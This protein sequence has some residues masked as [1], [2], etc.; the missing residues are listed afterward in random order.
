MG[1]YFKDHYDVIV[2]GGSLAGLSSALTL[3]K[4][5]LDVLVL[6]QH[7]LPG[8]VATSFVRGGVEME[9]SLHEMS[10]I[11]SKEH[12]LKARKY[13]ESFGINVDWIEIPY[14]Y[15][16]VSNKINVVVRPGQGG[17]FSKPAEDIAKACNDTDGSIYNELIRFFK[18]CLYCH[19]VSDEVSGTHVSKVKMVMK[20]LDYVKILGYSFDEVI[21]SFKLPELAI[22]I[23]SAYWMYLGSPVTDLPFIIYSYIIAD[24]LGYGAYIPKN[25]S[26]E[27]ALRMAE[28]AEEMGAQIEY[29]QRVEKILVKNKKV[30]GVRLKSGVEISA[31]QVISIAYPNTVYAQMIEPLSE[32][33]EKAIKTVN[34]M[35]IGVSCFSIV[36]LLDKNYKDL[37][38]KDYATFYVS[39]D[40]LDTKE[41][42]EQGK[43]MQ[44][45]DFITS[46]CMNVVNP[47]CSPEGTSVYSITYLPD[48]N[49]FRDMS[50]EEYEEYKKLNIENFLKLESE[51]LGVNLKEHILE[52]VVETPI[53]IA[54][55][56]TSY[57]GSIYGYRHTMTASCAAREQ[58]VNDERFIKGL[59]FAG[60]H[61]FA[62]DGMA[63]AIMSGEVAAKELIKQRKD[64]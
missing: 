16:Y 17:D 31:D 28:K 45:W 50:V 11:G 54:H 55:Y 29:G 43:T 52:M 53:T 6:E 56:T 57:F 24:Y 20:Y 60:A 14:A 58:K 21:R 1:K 39:R 38:I 47:K 61:H 3:R 4:Q 59:E 36:L 62:G 5:G 63:P 44:K 33:P 12:P 13:L 35:D 26:F 18:L 37:G 9:A 10:C 49:S 32:V 22:E 7:N 34:S 19:N 15:R 46:V 48:G 51:R 27:I 2:V 64:K 41:V 8:G 42:F 30:T 25:T 40:H 23:L